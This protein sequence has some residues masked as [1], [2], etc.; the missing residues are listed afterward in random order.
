MVDWPG[1]LKWT[2]TQS[3]GCK[4][5][6]D[7]KPMSPEEQKWLQQ[8]I[9]SYSIDEAKRMKEVIKEL[10]EP[11]VEGGS[12]QDEEK[13]L[14]LVEDLTDL[15][16]GL[17][18]A[19]DLIRMGVYS[20][21]V[22]SMF[23]SQYAEVRKGLYFAF[24]SCNSL[25]TFVQKGSTENGGFNLINS[26]IQEESIGNKE[27]AFAALSSIV[28]GEHFEAKR[29][30]INIDGIE[31]L[32]ELLK[33]DKDYKSDKMKI[34]AMTLLQDLVFYDDK[35]NYEDIV[36]FNKGEGVAEK[37]I[38]NQTNQHISLKKEKDDANAVA[39]TESNEGPN[40]DYLG[41]KDSVKNKLIEN[42]FIE[43]GEKYIRE[44]NLLALTNLRTAYFSIVISLLQYNP[45]VKVPNGFFDKVKEF[46]QFLSKESA[47]NDNVYEPEIDLVE[48]LL[49]E[50]KV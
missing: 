42:N 16:E 11:E 47:Q 49:N 38:G 10:E 28:R 6:T 5:N 23:K 13:R 26:V 31:F 37:K 48:S 2:L 19:R 9:E 32:L 8:A 7:A 29:I 24:A 21:L 46:K 27:A 14:N 41:F 39:G 34:K 30:F 44:N 15:V 36:S 20:S 35:L 4:L 17:E 3:D 33:N 50:C 43:L 22:S 45:S 1:L 40:Q 18:N 25:N 12:K